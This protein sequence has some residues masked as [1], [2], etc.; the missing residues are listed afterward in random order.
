[1]SKDTYGIIATF[2]T[3]PEIY[4]ASKEVNEAGYTKFDVFTPFPVHGIEKV[5]GERR[6]VLGG[7]SLGGGITGFCTGMAIVAFMNFNYPL[8]V[9]GKVI[10]DPFSLSLFFMN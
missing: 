5:M 1:M 6:S 9:G 2:D 3:S 10:L 4:K 7:F 8:I